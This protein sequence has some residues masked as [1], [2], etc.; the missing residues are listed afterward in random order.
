MI[1]TIW[2][3][4][5]LFTVI[6][7]WVATVERAM[8]ITTP[9]VLRHEMEIRGTPER[10]LWI[11]SKYETVLQSLIFVKVMCFGYTMI[12]FVLLFYTEPL[13]VAALVTGQTIGI[14]VF[15]FFAAVV[16]GAIARA[17]P[18]SS[19]TRSW[20]VIRLTSL[21]NPFIR[22]WTEGIAEIA[23]RLTGANLKKK[24][25]AQYSRRTTPSFHRTLTAR[26]WNS[27]ASS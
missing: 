14:V 10:G 11:E 5:I 25:G 7:A 4:I 20:L 17:V 27:S 19:V 2:I 16:A 15:W 22:W 1:G 23:R 3:L 9:L 13:T 26:R 12:G 8:T 18:V 21:V 6:G 24:C